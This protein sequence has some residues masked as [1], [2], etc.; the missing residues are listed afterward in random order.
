ML[1][2]SQEMQCLATFQIRKNHTQIGS[3]VNF[4]Q[5]QEEEAIR[6]LY[7]LFKNTARQYFQSYEVSIQIKGYQA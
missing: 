1:I 3:L 5:T 4:N 7:S 6:I 2:Y